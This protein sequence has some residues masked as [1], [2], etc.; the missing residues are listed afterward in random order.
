MPPLRK[1]A[2]GKRRWVAVKIDTMK[3]EEG[4]LL[5]H[6]ILKAGRLRLAWTSE[7]GRFAILE[8][9]LENYRELIDSIGSMEHVES[10]TSS[11]KIRLA[12]SRV[13]QLMEDH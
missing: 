2:R 8:V 6:L 13:F 11:G 4:T 3:I 7:D 12:K 10:I 5:E 9:R 1:A